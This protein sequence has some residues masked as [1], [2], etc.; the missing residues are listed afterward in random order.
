MDLCFSLIRSTKN[1]SASDVTILVF[2]RTA[3]EI[4]S[5]GADKHAVHSFFRIDLT[6]ILLVSP[7][8]PWNTSF[9]RCARMYDRTNHRCHQA[10]ISQMHPHR[11]PFLCLN[12]GLGFF[13]HLTCCGWIFII[14]QRDETDTEKKRRKNM[15]TLINLAFVRVRAHMKEKVRNT[16]NKKHLPTTWLSSV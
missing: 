9:T 16:D 6:K 10:W 5:Q 13:A 7:V 1:S 12:I 8:H 11:L 2:K 15:T 4:H 14:C 3:K